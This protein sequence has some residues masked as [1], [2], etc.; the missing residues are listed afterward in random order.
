MSSVSSY[1]GYA[2]FFN[3]SNAVLAT[4][5]AFNAGAFLSILFITRMPKVYK[6]TQS[7]T[8]II[9]VAGFSTALILSKHLKNGK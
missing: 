1:A 4:I 5:A 2:F 6:D 8:G 9:T 3:F 7:H